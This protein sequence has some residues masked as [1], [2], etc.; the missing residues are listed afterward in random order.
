MEVVIDHLVAGYGRRT[1][2]HGIT[3]RIPRGQ[4]TAVLGPNGS[5]KSTL[6]AVLARIIR[7]TSGSVVSSGVRRVGFV[8]QHSA[9]SDTLPIT[10]RETVAMG[11]WAHRGRWRRLTGHDRAVVEARMAQLDI[12][13]LA[14]RRLGS[15]SGGQRRRALLAQGLAQEPDLLLLDEPTTGLDLEARRLV[16]EALDAAAAQG[17]TVVHATHDLAAA[18]RAEHCL[19]LERGRLAA[20]GPP[21]EVL[22]AETLGRVIGLPGEAWTHHG[23]NSGPSRNS[24]SDNGCAAG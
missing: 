1:V 16:D 6:L 2:L 9:V 18:T 15:L 23:A 10:V 24:R 5:G 21:A 19:L 22:T 11:R 20:Q 17:V 4:V 7:P 14:S 8:P 13:P 3:A 12:L